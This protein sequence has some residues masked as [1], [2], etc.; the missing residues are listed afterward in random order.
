MDPPKVRH[1]SATSPKSL[2]EDAELFCSE[3]KSLCEED[4]TS[5]G[6]AD[7]Q[8]ENTTVKLPLLATTADEPS[9]LPPAAAA[10]AVE[11]EDSS[12]FSAAPTLPTTSL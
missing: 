1:L 11:T 2:D 10:S 7:E 9:V 8:A 5:P 4:D 12:A 6:A 3:D